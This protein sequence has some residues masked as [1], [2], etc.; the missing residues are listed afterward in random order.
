MKKRGLS[1]TGRPHNAEKLPGLHLQID[2]LERYQ[3]IVRVC[4]IAQA[5]ASER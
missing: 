1:A 3:P 4:G 2:V 5:D